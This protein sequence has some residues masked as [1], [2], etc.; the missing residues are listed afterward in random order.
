MQ[1]GNFYGKIASACDD[2]RIDVAV[3]AQVTKQMFRLLISTPTVTV[4]HFFSRGIEL[5][6]MQ[7]AEEAEQK[8]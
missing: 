3:V 2:P 8:G 5:A 4:L 1:W 6:E 7:E